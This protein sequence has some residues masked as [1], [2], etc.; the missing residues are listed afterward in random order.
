MSSITE[1]CIE[2]C[3]GLLRGE[4][5][6]VET[7]TQAIEKFHDDPAVS[8]LDQ[9]RAEHVDS[10]NRLR[11]NVRSMGGTPSNDSGAW[12]SFAKTVEGA[13]KLMGSSA[14]LK[15]L[16]QG[17][18][19]GKSSYE[20]ALHDDGVM[21]GCKDMIRVELLPRQVRHIATI[22]RLAATK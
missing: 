4:I 5:S 16:K 12:G 21:P 17:E 19:F 9:I 6:A 3:N 13:A 2:V 1:N 7:Y 11:E 22:D 20:E 14:A 10:A 18:E 8:T 15:G